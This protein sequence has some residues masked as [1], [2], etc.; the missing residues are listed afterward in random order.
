VRGDGLYGT[1]E[2]MEFLEQQGPKVF[3]LEMRDV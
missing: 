3:A 1:P 2:V